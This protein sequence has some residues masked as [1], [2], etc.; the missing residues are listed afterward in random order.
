MA[1]I[2]NNPADRSSDEGFGAGL[3]AGVLVLI[4]AG[5][6]FFIYGLPALRA[7]EEGEPNVQNIEIQVPAPTGVV[8]T[9]TP[10]PAP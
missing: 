1:T 7:V 9:P 8:T 3:V 6:L 10:E 4:F 5:L 2:I